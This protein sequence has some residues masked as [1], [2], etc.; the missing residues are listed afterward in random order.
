[1]KYSLLLALTLGTFAGCAHPL[2]RIVEEKHQQRM[3][4]AWAGKPVTFGGG[5]GIGASAARAGEARL[6]MSDRSR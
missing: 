1:M 2:E 5:D 4:E 6:T 3:D